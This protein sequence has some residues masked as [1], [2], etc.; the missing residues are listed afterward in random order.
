M[1]RVCEFWGPGGEANPDK[2]LLEKG[3]GVRKFIL[4]WCHRR[5][6]LYRRTPDR[7]WTPGDHAR[8]RRHGRDTGRSEAS[9]KRTSGAWSR[10]VLSL[11]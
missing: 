6:G 4:C 2:T 10:I 8:D 7:Q 3:L 11:A 1:A 5:G 9:Q